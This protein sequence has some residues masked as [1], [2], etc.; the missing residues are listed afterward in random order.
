VTLRREVGARL[1]ERG[2]HDSGN[3]SFGLRLDA[4]FSYVIDV[5]P[6]NQRTDVHPS[7]GLRCKLVEDAMSSLRDLPE[8]P[9]AAT[10]GANAGY[11]LDGQYRY[12]NPPA[13]AAEVLEVMDGAL[14][15]LDQYRSLE[16]IP[17]GLD[18][19]PAVS[20]NPSTGYRRVVAYYL[21]GDMAAMEAALGL[22][23]AEYT[24]HP[25]IAQKFLEFE[26]RIRAAAADS[27]A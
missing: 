15:V 9:Y 2:Y 8:G 1:R 23:R 18:E 5:G 6:L 25:E 24:R 20:A 17:R 7:V 12:F 21:L 3:G 11:V 19:V 27:V 26:T 16:A 4:D 10:I 22:A 14:G 13:S